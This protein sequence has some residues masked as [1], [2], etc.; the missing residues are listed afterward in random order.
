MARQDITGQRFGR[1]MAL[2]YAGSYKW[3]CV[4]D[5]GNEKVVSTSHLV[6]GWTKS[7]GCLNVETAIATNTHHGMYGTTEYH[8]WAS[9][10][11]RCN[12]PM[13]GD[14]SNYGG[15]GITVCEPWLKFENFIKD[16]GLKP[17]PDLS[18]ERMNN[19]DGY[20][21]ENCKW[22]TRTEQANNKRN[23]VGRRV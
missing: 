20:H 12:N 7:C 9:M 16:M 19:D 10:L 8:S 22:A 21:P 2:T 17:S 15:R 13:N 18:I 11:Q 3:K 6:T 5:C 4:C 14:Y 23:N 1:L